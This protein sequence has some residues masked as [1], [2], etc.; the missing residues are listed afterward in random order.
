MTLGSKIGVLID[1]FN[2]TNSFFAATTERAVGELDSTAF[3][4]GAIA[5]EPGLSSDKLTLRG[6]YNGNQAGSIYKKL[7]ERL[8][9][10]SVNSLLGI[11]IDTDDVNCVAECNVN[12]WAKSLKVNL[13]APELIAFDFNMFDAI[14]MVRGLVLWRGSVNATVP[15]QTVDFELA[16]ANGGQ[17]FV[18]VH[19]ITGTAVNAAI[20]IETAANYSFTSPILKTTVLFSGI[21]GYVVPMTGTTSRFLRANFTNLGGATAINVSVIAAVKGVTF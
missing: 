20:A 2:F 5:A 19:D 8:G 6:Y 11:L 21:G 3:G 18:F 7:R 16:G 13:A 14:S 17:V 1:E 15:K 9:A 4:A 10:G 12:G